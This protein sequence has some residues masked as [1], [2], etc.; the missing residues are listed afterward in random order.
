MLHQIG[1]GSLGPVF[2]GDDPARGGQVAIK[3]LRVDLP[4]ER[5]RQVADELAALATRLPVHPSVVAPVDAGLADLVPFVVWPLVE[6]VS[7]DVALREYGPAA[8][9]DA[10]PRLATLAEALDRAAAQGAWH[11]ALHPRDLLIA[12]DDTWVLGLGIAPILE[13]SGVRLSA[14]RPYTAPEQLEGHATSPQSDQFAL[15]AIAHEWLFGR[16]VAGPANESLTVPQLPGVDRTRM[17]GAFATAL[18]VDPQD[19]FPSCAD[20]IMALERAVIDQHEA[21]LESMARAARRQ[22]K[23]PAAVI[24][25][26]PLEDDAVD[27]AA[28]GEAAVVPEPAR[29]QSIE[30]DDDPLDRFIAPSEPPVLTLDADEGLQLAPGDLDPLASL[31]VVDDRD[32]EPVGIVVDERHEDARDVDADEDEDTGDDQGDDDAVGD[33]RRRVIEGD[34][35]PVAHGG[36]ASRFEDQPGAMF[37]GDGRAGGRTTGSFGA[38]SVAAALFVGLVI[39]T[40]AGYALALRQPV[41]TAAADAV[42]R[43]TDEAA[44]VAE[45]GTEA[46]PAGTGQS[47]TAAARPPGA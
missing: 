14:R 18:A 34:E 3:S 5:S 29:F 28:A 47:D 41:T 4:P 10:L 26:L 40:A 24:P 19:R 15:A 7:L 23:A 37:G 25:T 21:K 33:E 9:V 31:V 16:R 1:A 43:S 46:A 42:P 35:R 6:G 12:G 45:A 20:F 27:E 8:C 11:G 32:E 36:S 13:R 44:D 17:T 38:G 22:V 2:L 30:V 39:G